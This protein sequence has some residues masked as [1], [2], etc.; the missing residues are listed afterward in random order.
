MEFN[1]D[2]EE[3]IKAVKT[4]S[5]KVLNEVPKLWV[6]DQFAELCKWRKDDKHLIT[7]DIKTDDNVISGNII[8]NPRM[9]I[10]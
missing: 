9:L 2:N 10:L 3:N 1:F 5:V 7:H 6:S 8:L 4:P